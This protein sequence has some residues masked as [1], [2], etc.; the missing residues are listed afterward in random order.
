M[1][2]F[3]GH[4]PR[5]LVKASQKRYKGGMVLRFL[6][7]MAFGSIVFPAASVMA[8]PKLA[9]SFGDWRVFFVE[10]QDGDRLCYI[11]SLPVKKE[12]N[13]SKRGDAYVLVTDKGG[14]RD[15]VSV[16][17]GYPYKEN[18]DVKLQIGQRSFD[19]FGKG[20]MAWAYDTKADMEIVKELIRGADLVVRGTSW[21]GTSSKDTY[22]LTGFTDAHRAMKQL[23]Q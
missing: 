8:L 14:N 11:G 20:E 17:S 15:E 3:G 10:Q 23:C 6:A 18:Q 21:K 16:S 5:G 13:Y 9:Q 22:S 19:L 7:L 12:G 4:N 2:M 1:A